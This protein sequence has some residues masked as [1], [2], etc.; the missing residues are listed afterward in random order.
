MVEPLG[1]APVPFEELLSPTGSHG[2]R[3]LSLGRLRGRSELVATLE[4]RWLL[5]AWMDAILF[6]DHG[7]VYGPRFADLALDRAFTSVGLGLVAF[8]M[9]QVAYWASPPR[10]GVQLAVT[11]DDGL[12]LSFALHAW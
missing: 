7:D 10:Y 8:D 4:Y 1:A 6:V 11:P 2:L 3:G 9:D 12:R 5:A